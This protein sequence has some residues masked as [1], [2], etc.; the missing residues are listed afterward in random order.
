[1]TDKLYVVYHSDEVWIDNDWSDT[2]YEMMDKYF[3]DEDQAELCVE[4]L[5]MTDCGSFFVQEVTNGDDI[6]YKSLI[7]ELNR[8]QK[9][10]SDRRARKNRAQEVDNYALY[11]SRIEGCSYGEL[12][13]EFKTK[14]ADYINN[15]H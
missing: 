10:E 14:Y 3:T 2:V 9:E 7:E 1:M 8:K 11:K 4:Y 15:G 13:G 6:D 12:L 5:D